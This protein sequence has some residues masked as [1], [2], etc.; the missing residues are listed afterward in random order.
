MPQDTGHKNTKLEKKAISYKNRLN[1]WTI[2]RVAEDHQ[3]IVVARF[4]SKSDADG[5][6]QHLRQLIPD[7]YFEMFFDSQT[8]VAKM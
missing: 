8:L 3:R 6:I 1:G 7:S 4:R 2:A 5:Y